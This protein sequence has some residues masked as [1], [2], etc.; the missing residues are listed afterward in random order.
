M[1][2][3]WGQFVDHDINLTPTNKNDPADIGVPKGDPYFDPN[4]T[5]EETIGFNRSN[6]SIDAYGNRQHSNTITAFMD[7]SNVYGSSEAETNELRTMEGGKL[8]TTAGNLLP[9]ITEEGRE[10]GHF[11]AGDERANEHGGLTSMHTLWMP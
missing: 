9:I 7:G 2:W 8:N 1:F 10:K 5:G 6:S 11:L 4:G 3:L